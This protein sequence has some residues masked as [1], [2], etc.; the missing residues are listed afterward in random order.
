M[1]L[2]LGGEYPGTSHTMCPS[3][4]SYLRLTADPRPSL[5]FHQPLHAFAA[6]RGL[7]AGVHH[8]VEIAHIRVFDA[9]GKGNPE[10]E[11]HAALL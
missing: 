8:H 5:F 10:F 3:V 6:T 1:P 11:K 9:I 7:F 4:L 2:F